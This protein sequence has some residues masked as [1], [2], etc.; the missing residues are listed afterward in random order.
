MQRRSKTRASRRSGSKSHRALPFGAALATV[1]VLTVVAIVVNL[2]TTEPTSFEDTYSGP[3]FYARSR[4][5]SL[6]E[7]VQVTEKL[8][9]S[10]LYL[11]SELPSGLK[12]TAIYLKEGPFI[13]IVVYSAE[14]NKDYKT[15]ECCIEIV[16]KNIERVPTLMELQA[17]VENP[18]IAE[19]MPHAL[20]IN[21][22]PVLIYENG[23]VGN[24]AERRAKYGGNG[25]EAKV[26][27]PNLEYRIN[28][29]TLK[30]DEAIQLIQSMKPISQLVG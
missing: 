3:D 12:L 18:E 4:E 16:P 27:I 25:I 17:K 30:L 20:T 9:R 1:I 23:S 13:A 21:D 6:S 11:S 5:V 24:I 29:P 26:W 19:K 15:A 14:G 10:P 2:P 28:A 22:R 8:G 7:L